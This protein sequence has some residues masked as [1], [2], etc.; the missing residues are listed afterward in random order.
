MKNIIYTIILILLS[1]TMKWT[2]NYP[3]ITLIAGISW[4]IVGFLLVRNVL[5][6]LTGNKNNT[7]ESTQA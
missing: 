1:F 6:Y 3:V 5:R 2:A 4:C 7:K